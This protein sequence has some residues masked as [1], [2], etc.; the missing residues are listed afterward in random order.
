M[1]KWPKDNKAVS[2]RDLVEPARKAIEFA[3]SMER[4]NK[5][6]SIPWAGYDIGE[7][8]KC[9]SFT[10]TEALRRG[11]LDW[12]L[13]DQGR[14]A[15]DVILGVVI[16]TA[17]E[18]GRRIAQEKIQGELD[19]L[20]VYAKCLAQSVYRLSADKGSAV[21]KTV[22]KLANMRAILETAN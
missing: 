19:V 6:R 7:D 2:F 22:A 18:Q 21:S 20:A 11:S 16:Q 17:I 5:R 8:A 15:L 14:E 13:E 1:K 10:P 3:C 12:Q 9:G 4:K